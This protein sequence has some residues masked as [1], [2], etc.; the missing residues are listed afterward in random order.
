MQN[1][2]ASGVQSKEEL[3]VFT[4]RFRQR[5]LLPYPRCAQLRHLPGAVTGGTREEERLFGTATKKALAEQTRHTATNK[6]HNLVVV[7]SDLR[8]IY[9]HNPFNVSVCD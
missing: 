1:Q 7:S 4:R 8:A 9:L 5:R 2:N 3:I 6:Q